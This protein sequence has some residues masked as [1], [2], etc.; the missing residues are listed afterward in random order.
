VENAAQVGDQLLQAISGLIGWRSREHTQC[1]PLYGRG[2]PAFPLG[3]APERSRV[4]QNRDLKSRVAGGT[5]ELASAAKGGKRLSERQS[6]R[7]RGAS[8]RSR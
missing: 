4:V 2:H 7:R 6:P 5:V 8:P 3:G 1:Y